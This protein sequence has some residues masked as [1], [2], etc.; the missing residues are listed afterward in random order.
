MV[1][2]AQ[3]LEEIMFRF[4]PNGKVLCKDTPTTPQET[5][6]DVFRFPPN[7]KVLFKSLA[8]VAKLRSQHL[9]VSIPSEREG[10][11]QAEGEL[12]ARIEACKFP[13]PPNGKVLFKLSE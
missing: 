3:R 9:L 1:T 4:P 11:F 10:A 12:A 8:A 6:D 13:F 7:G 2:V 5:S